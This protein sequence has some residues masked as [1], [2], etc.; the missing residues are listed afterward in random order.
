MKTRAVL[1]RL[2]VGAVLITS[3]VACE[4]DPSDADILSDDDLDTDRIVGGANTSIATVPWQVSIQTNG[5]SHFC[6]GSIIDASWIL[7][8]AHCVSGSS[9]GSMRIEAGVTLLSAAGQIRNVA[10]IYVAP[11]YNGNPSKGKDAA[12]LR[13]SS[14]LTLSANAAVVDL[15]TT[16][17]ATYYAPGDTSLVS[18]W[19]TLSS[20]GSSPNNLQS[21]NIPI[22][23]NAQA[24]TAY[25]ASNVT[26][27]QLAAGVIG[28][29]GVDACQGDSGGPL[30]VSSPSGPLL[31]G[32]VSWG[33]GCA[34]PNYPGMYARVASFTSWID[35]TVASVGGGDGG[36]DGGDD[37]GGGADSCEGRC[38]N[39]NAALSCQCDASCAQYGDC[40]ADEAALC[41]AGPNSCVGQCGQDAGN[42]WCDAS[43]AQYGDCCDNKEAVCG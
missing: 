27:D 17:D 28:V 15:A 40:C 2:F 23:S 43:C 34:L 31:A 7:T 13:L 3:A 26:S 14:P 10:Q 9:A 35:T 4:V 33:N 18:G 39:Y 29:G 41:D 36:D 24:T 22:V 21:V 37:G 20:G 32:V 38:G 42:C 16:A 11:G 5:G 30:V 25:G 1:G 8:A 19:G 6:G 12:L